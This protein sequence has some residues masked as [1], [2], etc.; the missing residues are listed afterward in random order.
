MTSAVKYEKEADL[1]DVVTRLRAASSKS[2]DLGHDTL[3]RRIAVGLKTQTRSPMLVIISDRLEQRA[4]VLADTLRRLKLPIACVEVRRVRVGSGCVGVGSVRAASLLV[5]SSSSTRLAIDE[6]TWLGLVD[7]E[8]IHFV[9]Q[10]L[11][12]WAKELRKK[13]S[14]DMIFGSKELGLVVKSPQGNQKLVAISEDRFYLY[15]MGFQSLGW[16]DEEVKHVRHKV[17]AAIR[18]G[19]LS[20]TTQYPSF[21]LEW[22]KD[23]APLEKATQD[24]GSYIDLAARR[25]G[26]KRS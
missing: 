20:Q 26:A 14:C 9:R 7:S 17:E 4:L 11:L 19:H 24:L 10:S 1:A 3:N 5:T 25:A 16:S 18:P 6:E 13:G 23:P 8:P 12:A 22:L 15:L 21:R 2:L